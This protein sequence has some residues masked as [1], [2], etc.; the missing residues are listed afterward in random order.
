MWGLSPPA[1]L[2]SVLHT[3]F[4]FLPSPGLAWICPHDLTAPHLPVAVSPLPSVTLI[5]GALSPTV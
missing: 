4:L 3:L 1:Y 2:T 5:A